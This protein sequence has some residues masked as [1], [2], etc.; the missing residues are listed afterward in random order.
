MVYLNFFEFYSRWKEMLAP[1]APLRRS[2][3]A[4]SYVHRACGDGHSVKKNKKN[5]ICFFFQITVFYS[6]NRYF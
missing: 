6:K 2:A 1:G 5:T 3:S 4:A